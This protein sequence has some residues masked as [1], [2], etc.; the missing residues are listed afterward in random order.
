[1]NERTSH[2]F[3]IERTRRAKSAIDRIDKLRYEELNQKIVLRSD[4]DY[5]LYSIANSLLAMVEIGNKM[6][7]ERA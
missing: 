2:D 5:L 7:E 6:R 1:M 3:I 4:T